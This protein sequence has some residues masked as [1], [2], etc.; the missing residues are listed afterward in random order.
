MKITNTHT[1]TMKS[2]V[3]NSVLKHITDQKI[4]QK[5]A[6]Y[7]WAQTVLFILG[8]IIFLLIGS[9]ASA[10]LF[11]LIG[12]LP[13]NILLQSRSLL[14]LIFLGLPIMWFLIAVALGAISVFVGRQAEGGHRYRWPWILVSAVFLQTVFGYGLSQSAMGEHVEAFV[15]QKL[16]QEM[17][18]Q[19]WRQRAWGQPKEGLMVGR[20]IQIENQ[21]ITIKSPRKTDWDI[22]VSQAKTPPQFVPEIG[23]F[24]RFHGEKKSDNTFVADRVIMSRSP[25]RNSVPP[26]KNKPPRDQSRP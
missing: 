24:L 10:S 14:K 22:D 26:N 8:G 1:N 3:T 23:M 17:R 5:P 15:G 25:N 7:F 16:R 6:W 13:L 21:I 19:D 18:R 2:K 9:L 12:D 20:V 4:A 11:L